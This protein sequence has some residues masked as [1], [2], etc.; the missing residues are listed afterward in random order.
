MIYLN[1]TIK[2]TNT[3]ICHPETPNMT[4]NCT[5]SDIYSTKND[6]ISSLEDTIQFT[7]YTDIY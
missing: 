4:P 1:D 6:N 3:E 7:L 5:S 2:T